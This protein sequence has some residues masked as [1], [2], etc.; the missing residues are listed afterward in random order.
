MIKV[1]IVDDQDLIRGS[2]RIVLKGEKDI[3]VVGLASN[4]LEAIDLYKKH[5]PDVIL[6]DIHMPEMTGI[7][8]L[9]HIKQLGHKSSVIMLTTFHDMDYVKE[10]LGAGADGYLLKAMQP[11]DLASSIR[12]VHS[13][14]TLIPQELAKQMVTEWTSGISASNPIKQKS[15]KHNYGLTQRETDVL[16]L[17]VSGKDNRKIARELYLTEG[18]V[19]NYISTIYS[20]LEVTDRVQAILKAKEENLVES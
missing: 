8:A 15:E 5:Q 19:K 6:M 14:G 2:L 16:Q 20:K 3:D 1:L 13:G 12:I 18:T 7:E 4:G 9:R 17:L 10:A 11:E